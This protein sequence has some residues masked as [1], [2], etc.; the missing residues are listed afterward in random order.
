MSRLPSTPT[1]D[2]VMNLEFQTMILQ[3]YAQ[4]QL[5]QSTEFIKELLLSGIPTFLFFLTKTQKNL[6]LIS[7][8]KDSFS[9][10]ECFKFLFTW[11]CHLEDLHSH[12]I[13]FKI[14]LVFQD[15][16]FLYEQSELPLKVQKFWQQKKRQLHNGLQLVWL[17]KV[18]SIM[19]GSTV[20]NFT[21]QT[22][23]SLNWWMIEC[24]DMTPL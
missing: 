17:S 20:Q 9:T 5:K 11:N 3:Q 16:V 2:F 8:C 24:N 12:L 22:M 15:Q 18:L 21:R 23:L 6:V 1:L 7:M 19:K 4:F 14:W 10:R 13:R